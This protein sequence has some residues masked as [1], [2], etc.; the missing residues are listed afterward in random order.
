MAVDLLALCLGTLAACGGALVIGYRAQRR[1][2]RR[3]VLD[4]LPPPDVTVWTG[5]GWT[6]QDGAR[7]RHPSTQCL[8][9]RE[10]GE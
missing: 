8:L 9:R 5:E 6:E 1:A 3:D 4:L 10:A 2:P 7:F